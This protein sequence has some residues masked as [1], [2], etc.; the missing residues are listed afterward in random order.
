MGKVVSFDGIPIGSLCV[1]YQTD[2]T[3]TDKDKEFLE[4][5]ASAIGVEEKR[6]EAEKKMKELATAVEQSSDWILITDRDGKI[7]YVNSAVE[8]ISGYK[9]DEILNKTPRIFK[10]GKYDNKFY[11]EMW[12]TILSGQTFSGILTNRGKGGESFEIYHTVTPIRDDNGKIA[13]FVATSKDITALKLMEERIN[14]LANYDDLTKLPNRT[15]FTDRLIQAVSRAEYNEKS[16]AVLFIDIDRFH[17]IRVC[18]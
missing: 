7:E 17:L 10:S 16:T 15:L 1:V 3:F 12:N 2:C 9:R 18:L 11:K 14:F 6:K 4:I 5:V 8:R 13:R